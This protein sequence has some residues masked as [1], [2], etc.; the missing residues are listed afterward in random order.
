[1]GVTRGPGAGQLAANVHPSSPVP[2][3]T[4]LPAERKHVS[5]GGQRGQKDD[6][7]PW[8]EG[9]PLET[10]AWKP[11]LE[12]CVDGRLCLLVTPGRPGPLSDPLLTGGMVPVST[13]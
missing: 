12:S 4:G 8:A 3:D 9:Q 6:A 11:P 2:I 10:E 1:M 13:Q 5:E 7:A